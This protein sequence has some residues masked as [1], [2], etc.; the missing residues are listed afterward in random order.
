MAPSKINLVVRRFDPERDDRP[1]WQEFEVEAKPGGRVLD[2]LHD[3]KWHQDG[4]LTF[5]RSCGHGV[6][7]SDAMVINGRNGLACSAPLIDLG[8]DVILEPLRA[9]PVVKDLVVDMEPFFAQ[10]ERVMPWLVSAE[11]PGYTERRQ[12]PDEH[13]AYEDTAKCI[14]CA[15]CTTACP[16]SWTRPDYVGPAALVAAHRFVFDSR[17]GARPERLE[18]VDHAGG[19]WGCRSAFSC[20]DACP[21]G[22]RV[23]EAIV[24]LR[25]ATILDR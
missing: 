23:T 13:A 8:D 15:A 19:V 1:Y 3:V 25:R 17:D 11:D 16:V 14:L 24:E 20:T 7:G 12:T 9:L 4:T 5:R 22:I 10:Y 21:R 6:C 2:A 18:L